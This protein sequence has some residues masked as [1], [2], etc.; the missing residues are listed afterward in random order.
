M[1]SVTLEPPTFMQITLIAVHLLILIVSYVL[2]FSHA[3]ER[4]NITADAAAVFGLIQTTVGFWIGYCVST[5]GGWC[6]SAA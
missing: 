1:K 5:C 6:D 4:H 3:D 2:V